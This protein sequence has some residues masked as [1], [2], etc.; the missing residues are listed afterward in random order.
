MTML[1]TPGKLRVNKRWTQFVVDACLEYLD[2]SSVRKWQNPRSDTSAY[3]AESN[4][5]VVLL[6]DSPLL[7]VVKDGDTFKEVCIYLGERTDRDGNP[8]NIARERLNGLL[9]ILGL[10]QI[11]PPDV[12]VSYDNK[13]SFR[14]YIVCRDQRV[15]FGKDY[16]DKV[17]V[18]A[19]PECFQHQEFLKED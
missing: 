1:H 7:R 2:G 14:S 9:N 4:D 5:F 19:N 13:E 8:T 17:A 6:H 12:R 3:I 18:K 10:R 11:I 16:C 15:V